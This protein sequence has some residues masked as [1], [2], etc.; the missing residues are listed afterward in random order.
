MNN[1]YEQLKFKMYV[2][3]DCESVALV[4]DGEVGVCDNCGG[5]LIEVKDEENE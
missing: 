2:C 4:F 3:E 5:K 1:E